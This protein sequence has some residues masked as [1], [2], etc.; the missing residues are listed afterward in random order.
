MSK[1]NKDGRKMYLTL[2]YKG[3]SIHSM[4]LISFQLGITRCVMHDHFNSSQL[5]M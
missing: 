5:D 2:E 4:Y 3:D 1:H